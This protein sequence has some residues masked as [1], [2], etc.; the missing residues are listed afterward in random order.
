MSDFLIFLLAALGLIGIIMLGFFISP[1]PFRAHPRPSAPG[2]PAPLR[3]DLLEPAYSHFVKTLGPNPPRIE[4][5]VIWGRGRLCIR[6]VWFPLRFKSW[7]R[8]GESFYRRMEIT[9]YQRP[10]F[11]GFVSYIDGKGAL[12]F[13]GKTERGSRIDQGQNLTLW[14]EAVW[15]PSVFVH[16]PRIRWEQLDEESVRLIVPFGEAEDSLTLYFDPSTRR[17]THLIA[18]RL[19]TDAE[20]AAP[21]KEVWR[22]DLLTWKE[23]DLA[24]PAGTGE[25][26][27]LLIPD[28]I[29][30]AR[31]EAGS[32]WAYWTVDGAAYNVSVDDQLREPL[33]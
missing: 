17:M 12:G 26:L 21:E 20:D 27:S 16:D 9:W 1:R 6:G 10:I 22:M 19:V 33:D 2:E 14:A 32:P 25:R 11:R 15:T 23:F 4:S 18:M 13:G 28:Q 30:F 7:Y 3:P 31:G 29:S 5:A 8:P 24:S